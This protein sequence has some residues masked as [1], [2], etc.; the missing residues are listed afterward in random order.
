MG[1]SWEKQ[2][3]IALLLVLAGC[4]GSP[5]APVVER[6][7]PP[8]I[9][10]QTHL[11]APG[12]T[13]YSIA[14]RYGKDWRYLARLNGISSPSSLRAGQTLK[15]AGALPPVAKSSPQQK[16]RSSSKP[17][18]TKPKKQATTQR[19]TTVPAVRLGN[20]RWPSSAKLGKRY[21]AGRQPHKGIDLMGAA[22]DSVHAANN[23]TVVY[24]GTGIRGYGNLLIIK[25]DEEYLSAYA[26]NRRLLVAEKAKV[27]AG[28]KIAEMGDS[29]SE[30][31]KLHF[32]VRRFGN[33]VDPLAILPPRR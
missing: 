17:T 30:V 18:K 6:A 16:P 13:L 25:H 10:I 7:Q 28:Q 12:E 4:S 2:H 14:W 21:V 8:S 32:E 29:D 1:L 3:W 27:T 22:G 26:H 33:P 31:V 19:T 5:Y 23:G 20:W 24:A 9:K 15:L 11:V